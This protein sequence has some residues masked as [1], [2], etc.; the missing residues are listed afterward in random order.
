[1]ANVKISEL[2][3]VTVPLAGTEEMPV[4]QGGV[5]KRAAIN[6]ILSSNTI[7]YIANGL[8]AAATPSYT[9]TGDLNTGMW[10]P[11]ADT[12]AF[13]T[14]G[15][16]RIRIASNGDVGINNTPSG[17]KLDVSGLIR[18]RTSAA[19]I[20][21]NHD[22]VNGS[23][24][25]SNNLLLYANG[26][27]SLVSHTNSL[28][29]M[30][31]TSAGLVGI[32]TSAPAYTLDVNG[33]I[34]FGATMLSG[35]G[36]ATGDCAFE[37][38]ANRSA[39]GNAYIDFHAVAG[40]DQE[41][42][43]IRGG[44]ANGAFTI[45]NTGTGDMALYNTGAAAM[46]FSTTATERMRINSSGNVGIGTATPGVTLDVAGIIRSVRDSAQV[47]LTTSTGYGW[48]MGNTS[49]GSTL[50][51]IYL[52]GTTDNFAT[53]FIDG[54]SISSIGNV[55]IG[56]TSPNASAI[57]DVQ[58]TTKGLRLPNMTTVQKNAIATPAAGLMVFD[59]T[60]AKACVYSG[61]AW[62]TITSV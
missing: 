5:T 34:N 11:A 46:T 27:S 4:V 57:L 28:E 33:N 58:S 20:D 8:G 48:R 18:S 29:R 32:G 50:G 22:G 15:S 54:L 23:V 59:T 52:Q 43:L 16:E 10:S 14:N 56:T 25:S 55:G 38:G 21:V 6:D 36:V 51:Y 62:Q 47:R 61:A 45:S 7:S 39:S 53:S 37:L 30:R 31:V 19:T 17:A 60:L 42:R 40:T 1:M 12:V 3:A 13:S 35:S 9:F 41:A 24:Q 26:A 49:A 2:P 44:G